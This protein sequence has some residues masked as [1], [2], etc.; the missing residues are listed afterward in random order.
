[1]STSLPIGDRRDVMKRTFWWRRDDRQQDTISPDLKCFNALEAMIGNEE[2]QRIV[3]SIRH[4]PHRRVTKL[5]L[6]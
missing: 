5:I 2:S 4:Q 3:T 1:M 6:M